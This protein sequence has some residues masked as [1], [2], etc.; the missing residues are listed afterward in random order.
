M[1]ILYDLAL[2]IYHWVG[3]RTPKPASQKSLL[4]SHIRKEPPGFQTESTLPDLWSLSLTWLSTFQPRMDPDPLQQLQQRQRPRL[5]PTCTVV[6]T[7]ALIQTSKVLLRRREMSTRYFDDVSL[8]SM[9]LSKEPFSL[10]RFRSY[11]GIALVLKEKY[12]LTDSNKL[13]SGS[14]LYRILLLKK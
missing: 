8:A 1:R 9:R 2:K 6:L 11:P 4:F 13:A 3:H 10:N 5:G 12:A 7:S 14:N